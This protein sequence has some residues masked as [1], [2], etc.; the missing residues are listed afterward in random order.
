MADFKRNN[1]FSRGSRKPFDRGGSRAPYRGPSND[2]ELF[3]TT[4]A[5][6]GTATKV[7]FRPNGTKPVYCRDC[8][9]PEESRAPQRFERRDYADKRA[10][11]P[12]R[13]NGMS[14]VKRELER[15]NGTLDKI[16]AMLEKSGRETALAKELEPYRGPAKAKKPAKKGRAKKA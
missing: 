3:D 4:C 10:F 2:R 5:N 7:P 6:C 15:M 11:A 9:K 8:F 1:R 14:E 16:A 12:Q 13:D